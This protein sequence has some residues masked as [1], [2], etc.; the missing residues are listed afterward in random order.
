MAPRGGD[1]EA[2]DVVGT[3]E[4]DEAAREQLPSLRVRG[5]RERF[6][7]LS[8]GSSGVSF[9]E[10]PGKTKVVRGVYRSE[11]T[12]PKAAV[13]VAHSHPDDRSSILPGP[14]DNLVVDAGRP[15]Y[16]Y[17]DGRVAVLERVDGRY[18]YRLLKGAFTPDEASKLEKVLNTLQQ[19]SRK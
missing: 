11:F 19:G 10:R 13:A 4:L 18:T 14:E 8:T 6:G 5:D 12:V 17:H 16:I 9:E 7:A 15:S 3:A 1:L 2:E